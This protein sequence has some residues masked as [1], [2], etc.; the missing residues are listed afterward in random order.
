MDRQTID[1]YGISSL[2]L[3]E[4]A[5]R[6]A[7]R[8][9]MDLFP[10]TAG[11]RIGIVAG[12]GNPESFDSCSHGA[13]LSEEIAPTELYTSWGNP[14][15]RALEDIIVD[16]INAGRRL[17]L[18]GARPQVCDMLQSLGAASHVKPGKMYHNRYDALLHARKILS[19]SD[20]ST[21]VSS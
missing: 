18:V 11:K 9:M 7:T 20:N 13:E 3:M 6:G 21:G 2:V 19:E 4:N 14:T 17:F 12:K 8:M 15:T 1:A 16:T 5:G 10:E